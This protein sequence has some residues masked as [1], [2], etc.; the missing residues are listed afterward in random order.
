[1]RFLTIALFGGYLGVATSIYGVGWDDDP[2]TAIFT[3]AFPI[4]LAAPHGLACD[5]DKGQK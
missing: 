3:N 4:V 5:I 1:M 2:T